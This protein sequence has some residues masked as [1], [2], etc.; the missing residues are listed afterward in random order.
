MSRLADFEESEVDIRWGVVCST[1]ASGGTRRDTREL[2]TCEAPSLPG[3]AA[4]AEPCVD[5]GSGG[6][7]GGGRAVAPM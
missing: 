6:G 7:G 4:G 2:D 5:S 1:W 3:A